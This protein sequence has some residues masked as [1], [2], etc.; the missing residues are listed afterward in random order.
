VGLQLLLDLRWLPDGSGF[1][2]T[3]PDLAYEFG[4]LFRYDFA[5]KRA[6]QLTKF[7]GEYARAFDVSP[8]GQWVVFERAKSWREDKNVDL[9]LMRTDGTGARLLVR[10]GLAP[11]WR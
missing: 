7:E 10:N 4:N 8:D 5:T 11:S 2:Y 6:T 9:W 1:L 3:F